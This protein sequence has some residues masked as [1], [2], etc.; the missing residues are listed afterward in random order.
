MMLPQIAAKTMLQAYHDALGHVGPQKMEMNVHRRFCWVEMAQAM[1]EW[2][3]SCSVC[4]CRRNPGVGDS[5]PLQP[6]E[7][8]SPWELVPSDHL[9]V[10]P[11]QRTV[12]YILTMVEH[13]TKFLVTTPLREI[14]V[15]A[16]TEAYFVQPSSYPPL[17][18]GA[19]GPRHPL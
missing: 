7:T 2:C 11:S 9:K 8:S 6:I 16:T 12:A 14:T 4:T 1:Q 13:Y 17:P 15:R 3:N 18:Q 19:H 10:E 5:A